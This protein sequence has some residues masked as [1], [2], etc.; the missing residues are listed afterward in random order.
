M[1]GRASKK[2]EHAD[3][4]P[5]TEFAERVKRTARGTATLPAWAGKRV[6]ASEGARQYWRAQKVLDRERVASFAKLL[7]E[8]QEIFGALLDRR[9]ASV[10]ELARLVKRSESNVSRSLGKLEKLG[11]VELVDGEGRTRQ[12]ILA[13]DRVVIEIDLGSGAAV[14]NRRDATARTRKRPARK[15]RK[16]AAA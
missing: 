14:I 7:A 2:S 8:N 1:K 10:G 16:P 3:V 15:V 4:V 5:F 9:P 13:T 6:Y 12:P 11:I